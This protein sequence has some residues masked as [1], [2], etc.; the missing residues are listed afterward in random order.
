MKSKLDR[1]IFERAAPGPA[2]I[3]SEPEEK[4]DIGGVPVA[5]RGGGA[6]SGLLNWPGL[7]AFEGLRDALMAG[8]TRARADL[9]GLSDGDRVLLGDLNAMLDRVAGDGGNLTDR[10]RQLA[11]GALPEPVEF[12]RTEAESALNRLID[13]LSGLTE[14]AEVLGRMVRNDHEDKVESEHPGIFGEVGRRVNFIRTQLRHITET[15]EHI[16]AGDLE[17]LESYRS[18]GR[19]SENDQIGPAFIAMMENIAGL[20]TEAGNLT[21]A[22][23]E[24]RLSVRGEA[25]RFEGAYARIVQGI[26]NT[27]DAVILPLREAADRIAAVSAGEIPPPMSEDYRGDFRTLQENI[28]RLVEEIGGVTA[29]ADAISRGD[30]QVEVRLRSEGDALMKALARMVKE[31]TNI[32]SAIQVAADEVAYAGQEIA[33]SATQMSEGATQQSASV[34]EISSSMEQI[35]S[36]VAHNADNARETA[37]IAARL[38]EDAEEG[39]RSVRETVSAMKQIAERITV[40]EEI[41]RQTNMLALNAAI[42]AARA[43]DHGRGFAV[44]AAE[45]R[46]LAERSQTA[47]KEIGALSGQSVEIAERAGTLIDNIVPGV[48]KTSELVQE[49]GA[50]SGEQSNG[51]RHITE[52][53]HQLDNVV[54]QNASGTEQM[55]ATSQRLADAAAQLR[56]SAGFFQIGGGEG[57]AER[58]PGPAGSARTPEHRPAGG[59]DG[60]ASKARNGGVRLKLEP[61]EENDFERY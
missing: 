59:A 7:R 11:E 19:R 14:A 52:A 54:Q 15:V 50:S 36:T 6:A 47:A 32:A 61:P 13:G 24:G 30:L 17:D 42:E 20:V 5:S 38:A 51:V 16:A 3:A 26:N 10:L 18:I 21:D 27:L 49:I 57:S 55:A 34:E 35:N 31:L 43:G 12:P 40:I 53:I 1:S 25:E 58:R 2:E 33:S 45:V 23:M 22:A 9:E 4:P 44:V 46:K 39:G 29:L 60:H 48:Q 8:D 28:N 41:A 56:R 37:A